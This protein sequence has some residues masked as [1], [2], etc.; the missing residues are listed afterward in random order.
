MVRKL[1]PNV[2]SV[3]FRRVMQSKN[4]TFPVGTH[5]V[6]RCGWRTRAICDGA[7][8]TPILSNWPEDVPLSLALGTIGMPG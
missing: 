3:F 1:F 8:L 2:S 7:T 6:A 5:V 4:A